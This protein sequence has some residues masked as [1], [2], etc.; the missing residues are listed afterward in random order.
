MNHWSNNYIPEEEMSSEANDTIESTSNST[1][2]FA[3]GS[4]SGLKSTSSLSN[5]RKSNDTNGSFAGI[6]KMSR[7]P[8]SLSG[9]KRGSSSMLNEDEENSFISVTEQPWLWG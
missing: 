9:K 6:A 3:A 2:A 7:K 1:E 4:K 5:K 8:L